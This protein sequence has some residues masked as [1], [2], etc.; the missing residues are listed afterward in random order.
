MV[1]GLGTRAVDRTDN[2]YPRIIHIDKP[3][4]TYLTTMNEKVRFSQRKLDVI[5]L[6]KKDVVEIS[7]EEMM[8]VTPR[9]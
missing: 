9:W 3:E 4:H 1:Y 7:L 6:E 2:D 5:H 8:K